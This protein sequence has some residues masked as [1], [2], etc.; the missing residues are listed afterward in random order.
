MRL[1]LAFLLV[2]LPTLASGATYTYVIDPGPFHCVQEGFDRCDSLQEFR[3]EFSLDEA[4]VPGGSLVNTRLFLDATAIEERPIVPEWAAD[5]W[6]AWFDEAF[7][8]FMDMRTGADREIISLELR[9]EIIGETGWS[10][11]FFEGRAGGR[12]YSGCEVFSECTVW[13]SGPPPQVAS[14]PLPAALP[15]LLAALTGLGLLSRRRLI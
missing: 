14:T 6:G 1:V 13:Q 10:L 2:A 5:V 11:G 4:L 3:H 8:V 9:L 15:L 7:S 12:V